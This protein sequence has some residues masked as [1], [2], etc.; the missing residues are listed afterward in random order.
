[1]SDHFNGRFACYER[2]PITAG[3]RAPRE[4]L[5]GIV[6]IDSSGAVFEELLR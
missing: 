6:A 5:V 3:V 2:C 1:M 4:R